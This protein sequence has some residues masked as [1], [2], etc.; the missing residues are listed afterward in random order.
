[1]SDVQATFS[2]VDTGCGIN[3]MGYNDI[4]GGQG[5]MTAGRC[6]ATDHFCTKDFTAGS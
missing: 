6:S 3:I 4:S 5:S 2:S 1:M